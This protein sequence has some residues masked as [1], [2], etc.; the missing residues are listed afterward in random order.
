MTVD[1][2][3]R[4][5]PDLQLARQFG[6]RPTEHIRP[7]FYNWGEIDRFLNRFG[8]LI[9]Q[10]PN[11][12]EGVSMNCWYQ[13]DAAH[14]MSVA[15]HTDFEFFLDGIVEL[16]QTQGGTVVDPEAI[17][18]TSTRDDI[19][20]YLRNTHR[21]L[22]KTAAPAG[23]GTTTTTTTMKRYTTIFVMRAVARNRVTTRGRNEVAM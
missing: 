5:G 8:V 2:N 11:S 22:L 9:V 14:V 20:G 1:P 13:S 21:V 7:P 23:F 10:V 16:F 18:T 12:V 6:T 17:R 19:R 15:A 3:G 4:M